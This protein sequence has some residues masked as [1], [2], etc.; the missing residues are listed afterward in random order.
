MLRKSSH[1]SSIVTSDAVLKG[2]HVSTEDRI[3][4]RAISDLEKSD[5]GPGI[6]EWFS[7]NLKKWK[8][9]FSWFREELSK[10][11]LLA[12]VWFRAINGSQSKYE[13]ETLP[14]H[15]KVFTRKSPDLKGRAFTSF[16]E[17]ELIT[18]VC[19]GK[20]NDVGALK[21]VHVAV[22]LFIRS[23]SRIPPTTTKY[24]HVFRT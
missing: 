17:N 2:T 6:L 10:S 4:F 5:V 13:D 18:I 20:T 21:Q 22:A 19:A 15:T 3:C 7:A 14:E 24:G 1:I 8:K 9:I 12:P 11:V 23:N 16:K